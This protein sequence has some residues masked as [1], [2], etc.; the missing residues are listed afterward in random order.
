MDKTKIIQ[1]DLE[2]KEYII[3]EF[4][5]LFATTGEHEETWWRML[6][7]LMLYCK[8]EGEEEIQ[9]EVLKALYKK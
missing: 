1:S 8:M 7:L 9:K 6:E 2:H 5:R 4:R 3:N